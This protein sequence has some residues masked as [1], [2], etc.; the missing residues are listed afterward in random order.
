MPIRD[1]DP[2]ADVLGSVY[3]LSPRQSFFA[4]I[5]VAQVTN[6]PQ[7]LNAAH[8]PGALIA[9]FLQREERFG[10]DLFNTLNCCL[11]SESHLNWIQES[12]RQCSWI[13]DACYLHP[14]PNQTTRRFRNL[15]FVPRHLVG[16]AKSVALVDYCFSQTGISNEERV[17]FCKQL[18][19]NWDLNTRLDRY[20]SWL[21]DGGCQIFLWEWMQQ[22]SYAHLVLGKTQFVSHDGLLEFFDKAPMSD[23]DKVSMIE[24]ARRAWNQRR[25]REKMKGRKQCNFVLSNSVIQKLEKLSLKYGLSRTEIVELIIDSEAQSEVYISERLKRKSL[26]TRPFPENLI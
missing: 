8:L 1:S 14:T 16:R 11:V 9:N 21:D 15:P 25:Q 22:P 10:V 20:F 26:L 12:E 24:K 18:Q 3:P 23:L 17:A 2:I 5:A 13:E 7:V 6:L 4:W 19:E